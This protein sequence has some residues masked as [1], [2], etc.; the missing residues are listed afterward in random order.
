MQEVTKTIFELEM[1]EV[2]AEVREY[3]RE[4]NLAIG[5][6]KDPKIVNDNEDDEEEVG[7][8]QA[9]RLHVQKAEQF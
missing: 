7:A 3:R 4:W 8:E 1:A 9:E 5:E 2:Q 6:G